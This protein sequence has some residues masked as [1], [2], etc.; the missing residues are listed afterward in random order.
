[1]PSCSHRRLSLA[2]RAGA[3]RASVLKSGEGPICTTERRGGGEAGYRIPCAVQPRCSHACA[4]SSL[5]S[6]SLCHQIPRGWG[7]HEVP[8]A[9]AQSPSSCS[10]L[11]QGLWVTPEALLAA[12]IYFLPWGQAGTLQPPYGH[13]APLGGGRSVA[14]A[15]PWE[16]R[17]RMRP[18]RNRKQRARRRP[19]KK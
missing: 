6:L 1:M 3:S 5:F 8:P 19:C 17:A 14:T 11:P 12:P 18:S 16:N 7:Q 9:G 4:S 13:A 2:R 10:C 15:H